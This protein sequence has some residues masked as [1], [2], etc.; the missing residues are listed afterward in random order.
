[1]EGDSD[2]IDLVSGLLRFLSPSIQQLQQFLSSTVSFFNGWRSTPGTMP[3]MRQLDRLISMT[4]ISVLF[5]PKEVRD[6]LRSFNFC[7][8]PRGWVIAVELGPTG[9]AGRSPNVQRKAAAFTRWHEPDESRGS[10]PDC[11]R[12][13]VKFPGPTRQKATCHVPRRRLILVRRRLILVRQ[14]LHD[15]ARAVDEELHHGRRRAAKA[16]FEGPPV[17]P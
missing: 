13:G 16:E 2:A 6:R 7:M 17:G 3:A 4:A 9:G 12:L 8:G 1:L 14:G 5:G 11:E 10:S 15:L